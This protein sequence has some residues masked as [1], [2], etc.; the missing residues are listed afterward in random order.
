[1]RILHVVPTYYPAVRYGGP[2][3]SV[4]GLARALAGRGHEV[5]VYTTNVDGSSNSNVPLGTPVKL[6]DVSVW[7]FPTSMG[8]RLYRSPDMAR[9][10]GA[11]IASFDIVHTHSVFLWPTTAAARAARAHH[12]PYVLA[13]RGM[14]VADLIRRKNWL[15]KRAW[16]AAF[17][18]YNVETA[19]AVHV[20]SH[21]EAHDIDQLRLQYKRA[22]IVANGADIPD[23]SESAQHPGISG[24]RP[25][26]LFLGRINWKKGIE[27]LITAIARLPETELVLAGD[28]DEGY[29][30][31][32]GALANNLGV[33]RRVRFLGPVHGPKKW[34]LLK[35]AQVL[36][37]P[38]YS[39][40]FG[41][42]VLE[43][44]AVGCPVVVT[45]EVG[46]ASVVRDSGAGLVTLGHAEAL[47]QAL[48][49]ILSDPNAARAMGEAGRRTVAQRFTWEAIAGDMERAYQ[50]ILVG[51]RNRPH[52]SILI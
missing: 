35:S 5:H 46:L 45:P 23:P 17:E 10:L 25:T 27:R 1:M 24:E 13:P 32:M 51:P 42:V 3:G 43:A 6:D 41:N 22:I 14:L 29:R 21:L 39:E 49:S 47:G 40:N 18:R 37:L 36:A 50:Q 52:A 34:A 8:R 26:V 48:H 38:S 15:L 33:A 9:A 30:A 20:T 19:A 7:Y 44:M 12:I 2:I 31:T 28:D 11:N 16:I 4:H